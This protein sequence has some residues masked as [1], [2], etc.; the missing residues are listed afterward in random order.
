MRHLTYIVDIL[1]NRGKGESSFVIPIVCACVGAVFA[2]VV[3]FMCVRHARRRRRQ[4]SG[5]AAEAGTAQLDQVYPVPQGAG[6]IPG[7]A[8]CPT[9][10]E[11]PPLT[12]AELEAMSVEQ[13]RDLK[14]KMGLG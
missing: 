1:G 2:V 13:L 12:R 11:G 8:A 6:A 14:G 4:A 3:T 9:V 5:A 10:W 7:E